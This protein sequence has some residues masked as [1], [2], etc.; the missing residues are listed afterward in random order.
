MAF[1][2]QLYLFF[3]ELQDIDKNI[4]PV[5]LQ[6]NIDNIKAQYSS[7]LSN[8]SSFDDLFIKNPNIVFNYVSVLESQIMIAKMPDRNS[9]VASLVTQKISI[10]ENVYSNL[11]QSSTQS[12]Q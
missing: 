4:G 11:M 5:M 8:S 9:N 3:P 6:S 7:E 1:R 10:L 2:Q 12:S